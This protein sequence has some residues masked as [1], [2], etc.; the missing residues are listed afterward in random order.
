MFQPWSFAI[1]A[2]WGLPFSPCSSPATV[3]KIIVGGKL[4][5]AQNPRAFQADGGSAAVIVRAR[6]V[7]FR[8]ERIAVARIIV[9]GHQHD[10]LRVLRIRAFEHRI[11]IGD[12]GGLGNAVRGRFGEGIGLHFQTAAAVFRVALEFR[13]EPL[14]R[15]AN[16]APSRDGRRVLRRDGGAASR[17]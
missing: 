1:L 8:I 17:S 4:Q 12:F 7:A 13:L 9:P 11:N 5:L 15:R 10:A 3:R 16:S 2:K 14:P 6:S